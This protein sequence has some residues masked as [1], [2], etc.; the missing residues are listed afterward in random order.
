MKIKEYG[1][2]YKQTLEEWAPSFRLCSPSYH[3]EYDN[4]KLLRVNM[5]CYQS[6]RPYLYRIC[7]WG[8]DDMGMELDTK[9]KMRAMKTIKAI[10]NEIY[11]SK[12]CLVSLGFK[13]A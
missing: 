3:A 11:L 6:K 7:V 10:I 2:F 5:F 8:A 4:S 12:Q 13:N 9:S 1:I